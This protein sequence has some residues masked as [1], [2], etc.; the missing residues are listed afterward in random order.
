MAR[1]SKPQRRGPS[2]NAPESSLPR[3]SW[4][5]ATI[6]LASSSTRP[7]SGTSSQSW[8]CCRCRPSI[9]GAL[10]RCWSPSEEKS[11]QSRA[12]CVATLKQCSTREGAA[13]TPP[14]GGGISISY[15]Q[16]V[17]HGMKQGRP[18]SD[19]G[20]RIVCRSTSSS[21]CARKE[22]ARSTSGGRRSRYRPSTAW[23]L[24]LRRSYSATWRAGCGGEFYCAGA[25]HNCTVIWCARCVDFVG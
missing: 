7:S 16:L 4:D 10:W 19:M 25:A 5:G 15:C 12:D 14:P 11:P 24:R 8:A 17:F 9:L 20:V 13:R 18:L 21:G 3:V 1:A 6:R 23:R 2:R 22:L